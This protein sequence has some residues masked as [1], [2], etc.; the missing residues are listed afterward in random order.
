MFPAKL[1]LKRGLVI[2]NFRKVV[3]T[4]T[5]I[6]TST[7]S[8]TYQH[9]HAMSS[10]A[11]FINATAQRRVKRGQHDTSTALNTSRQ[12]IN[13]HY[14]K[15]KKRD[16]ERDEKSNQRSIQKEIQ[17]ESSFLLRECVLC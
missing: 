4:A 5:Q 6:S 7:Q 1:C 10:T 14:C 2:P 11:Y 12:H 16:L 13:F 17:K 15:D 3:N 8:T 9:I